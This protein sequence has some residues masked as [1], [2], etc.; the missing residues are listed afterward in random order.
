MDEEDLAPQRQKPKPRDLT[1]VSVAELENYIAQLEAEI[2][3]AKA[4]IA[5]KR[6]QR[7]GAE[8]LFKR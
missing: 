2:A 5:A 3:R 1:P 7:G 8:E 6:R 4:E